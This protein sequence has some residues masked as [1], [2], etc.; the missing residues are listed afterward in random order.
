MKIW[1]PKSAWKSA[2]PSSVSKRLQIAK[3]KKKRVVSP[4]KARAAKA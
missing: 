3:S 1:L 2:G 4:K